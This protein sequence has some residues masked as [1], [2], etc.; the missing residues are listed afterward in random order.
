[1]NKK[2]VFNNDDEEDVHDETELEETSL[3]SKRQK[4]F[5][6]DDD[7]D[8]SKLELDVDFKL[9]HQFEGKK[10]QKVGYINLLHNFLS[11]SFKTMLLRFSLLVTMSKV[12]LLELTLILKCIPVNYGLF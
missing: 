11:K 3:K 1:M 5:D 9:N 6:D 2:I 12:L 8:N 4:L 7:E 10:G